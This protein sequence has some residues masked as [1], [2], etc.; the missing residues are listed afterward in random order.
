M[1]GKEG[2]LT[3]EQ[4][5]TRVI[6]ALIDDSQTAEAA[7]EVVIEQGVVTLRG[8][9]AGTEVRQAAEE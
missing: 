4:V 3:N 6:N 5:R 9:V 8:Q 1:N 7:I 2:R